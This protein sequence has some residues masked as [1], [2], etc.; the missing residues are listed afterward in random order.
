MQPNIVREERQGA[1]VQDSIF[2]PDQQHPRVDLEEIVQVLRVH[3]GLNSQM[4][5]RPAYQRPF[6]ERIINDYPLPRNYRPLD[7]HAFSGEDGSSTIEHLFGLSLTRTAFSWFVSLPPGQIQT[8]ERLEMAF[9]AR[10][11]NPLPT[12]SLTDLLELKQYPEESAS[13]FIERVRLMKGRC[14]TIINE[15]EMTNLVVRNMHGR[16]REALTAH[17]VEDLASLASK[18]ARL[19]SLFREKDQNF[20]RNKVQHMASMETE[21]YDF[22]YDQ[23]EEMAAKILSGKPYVCS[24]LKPILGTEGKEQPTFDN[25]KAD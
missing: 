22:D 16:L 12:I 19:E 6:P 14:P 8:W 3:F 9:H 20:R 7:F 11:F 23:T 4:A 10:F 13:Q 15:N 17:D 18:A 21:A 24:K 5:N 25:S 1:H 2:I